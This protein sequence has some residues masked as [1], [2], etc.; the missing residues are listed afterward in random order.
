MAPLGLRLTMKRVRMTDEEARRILA[1]QTRGLFDPS[2]VRALLPTAG[3]RDSVSAAVLAF[4]IGKSSDTPVEVLHVEP[5]LGAS[6]RLLR[7]FVRD[8]S[9][10]GIDEHLASL[11][12]LA[13][14]SPPPNT[15]RVVSDNVSDAILSEAKKGYDVVFMGASRGTQSIVGDV[16]ESAPCHLVI[17]RGTEK[18]VS[19]RGFKRLL[20][21][22]EGGILSQAAVEFAVRY[23]EMTEAEVT[24]ALV[25]EHRGPVASHAGVGAVGPPS[26]A[27]ERSASPSIPDGHPES[28]GPPAHEP[29]SEEQLERISR[30]FL[31]SR[32]KPTVLRVPYDP[33]Q[34]RIVAEAETGDYDLVV[35]GAENRAVQHRLF[36]GYEKERIIRKSPAAV[37][38]VVPNLSR[39][40][41]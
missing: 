7:L 24:L 19:S 13:N 34:N 25:A 22:I 18:E 5:R 26:E 17:V 33:T 1:S 32:V 15:S 6:Q 37:A 11:R 28:L 36:F 39:W 23:A 14:G 27:P 29:D 31:A 4:G 21:P 40:T 35:I 9:T 3:G 41:S 12:K 30:V 8:E 38:I 2:H 10:R 20:V 16:V